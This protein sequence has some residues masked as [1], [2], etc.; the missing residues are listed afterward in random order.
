M[1]ILVVVLSIVSLMS[2]VAFAEQYTVGGAY[3]SANLN[4]YDEFTG[5][6]IRAS[7]DIEYEEHDILPEGEYRGGWQYD[8]LNSEETNEYDIT[9]NAAS[10]LVEG[11]LG[12]NNLKFVF[13][14][15]IGIYW[16][17]DENLI[18]N[19][20]DDFWGLGFVPGIGVSYDISNLELFIKAEY[21]N[22]YLKDYDDMSGFG[23]RAGLVYKF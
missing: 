6:L 5:Y 11:R 16:G 14:N 23:Y 13:S 20:K 8:R 17:E 15:N 4:D 18:N 7:Y 9:L 3:R 12:S 19:T 10:I 21:S 2:G 22:I 1:L